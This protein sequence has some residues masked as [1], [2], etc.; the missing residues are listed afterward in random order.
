MRGVVRGCCCVTSAKCELEVTHEAAEAAAEA[1]A[2][3][4]ERGKKASSVSQSLIVVE[5][6]KVRKEYCV[7]PTPFINCSGTVMPHWTLS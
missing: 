2:V 6:F 1:A 5:N 7:S 4:K 3:A